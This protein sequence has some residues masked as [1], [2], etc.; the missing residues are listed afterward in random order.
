MKIEERL[1]EYRELELRKHDMKVAEKK[2]H[3]LSMHL[4]ELKMIEDRRDAVMKLIDECRKEFDTQELQ[5][6]QDSIR[7][8]MIKEWDVTGKTYTCDI[9]S[10]TMRTTKSLI[11]LSKEKLV[12]FLSKTGKINEAIS[13]FDLR[14]LRRFKDAGL[15][16]DC[17]DYEEKKSV[18]V[19]IEVKI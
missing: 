3:N 4:Q 1:G 15:L 5:E 11:I 7:E 14:V 16:E 18:Q 19:K 13:R 10:V 2:D 12:D 6:K 8:Q 9:G 17:T